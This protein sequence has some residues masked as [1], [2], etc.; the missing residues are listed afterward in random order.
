MTARFS[1]QK[2]ENLDNL[3]FVINVLG[4]QSV[5]QHTY[6]RPGTERLPQ[7]QRVDVHGKCVKYICQGIRPN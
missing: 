4:K 7:N 3:R 2:I 5:A 1:A 6:L